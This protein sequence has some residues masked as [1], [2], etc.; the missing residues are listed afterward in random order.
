MYLQCLKRCFSFGDVL[1]LRA[2]R[3]VYNESESDALRAGVVKLMFGNDML[4]YLST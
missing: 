1:F 3:F 4:R 2:G